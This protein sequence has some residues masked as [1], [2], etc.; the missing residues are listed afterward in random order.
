MPVYT[1]PTNRVMRIK[2]SLA[3]CLINPVMAGGYLMY[4]KALHYCPYS[5]FT[6]SVRISE[7]TV[8]VSLYSIIRF[9][10]L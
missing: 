1:T 5:A 2:V 7:Q 4:Q 8:I 9:V 3:L 6:C 10:F